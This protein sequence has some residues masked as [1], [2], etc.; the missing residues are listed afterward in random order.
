[1]SWPRVLAARLRGLFTRDRLERKLDYELRF[2]LEMQ[3]EDNLRMGMDPAEAR[4]A[5]R[6][7]FGGMESMKERYRDTR[8]LHWVDG[9][10]QDFHYAVRLMRRSPGAVLTTV[11]TL[12]QALESTQPCSLL[13]KRWWSV[14]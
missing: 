4:N 12:A 10:V 5:A 9:I 7:Q 8:G 13:I 6:R 3:I 11:A 1:M 14:R 2:H